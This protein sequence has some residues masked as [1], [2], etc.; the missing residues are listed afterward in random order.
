MASLLALLGWLAL[1]FAAAAVGGVASVGAQTFYAELMLPAWAP[2][3]WVFGPVW[4]VLYG[5]M[6]VA[7]WLIWRCP[8]SR[9]RRVA[10]SLFVAQ[11]AL[12]TLWSWLFFGW[13]LGAWSAIEIVLLWLLIAAT[14]VAFLR[15]RALAGALLVPYLAWVSFAAVLNWAVWRANPDLLGGGLL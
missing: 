8:A 14:L 6:A 3:A 7:A 4:T 5:A 12:N 13:R 9:Q 15:L 1:C 10:L 2:P 11:L